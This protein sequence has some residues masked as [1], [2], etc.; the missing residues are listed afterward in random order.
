MVKKAMVLCLLTLL[1]GILVLPA[2][3]QNE[4][5]H[6]RLHREQQRIDQGVRSG[7]LTRREDRQ[8]QRHEHHLRRQVARMHHRNGALTL[9]E[10]RRM[11]REL[12]RSSNRIWRKKHNGAIR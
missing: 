8:L 4:S 2:L 11:Q 12:N 10:R 9:R 7:E 3:A 6:A 5:V 1:M